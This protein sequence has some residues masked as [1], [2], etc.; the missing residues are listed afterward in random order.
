MNHLTCWIGLDDATTEN[1]CIQ[2]VPGSH[3]WPLLPM[4][5]LAKNMEAIKEVLTPE[6]RT[7]F[8]PVACEL[9]AGEAVFHHPLM[10]HGSYE[11][12]SPRQ[13]R[14]VVI[15]VFRDGT[16]SDSDEPL[17]EGADAIPRGE[18]MGGRFYPLLH[19]G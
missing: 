7:Q 4:T 2:Y 3:R 6:Q 5:H 14:A 1:G 17:L 18:K 9:K 13:R 12:T 10:L 15:N 11:N 8:K 19:E 16:T